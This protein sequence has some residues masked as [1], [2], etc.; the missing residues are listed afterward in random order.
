VP[1][2]Y[3]AALP[4]TLLEIANLNDTAFLAKDG[5]TSEALKQ[6]IP[7][8]LKTLVASARNNQLS[9]PTEIDG[10]LKVN[11]EIVSGG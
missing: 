10:F 3:G 4:Q 8:L 6:V 5:G 2:G 1:F 7:A 11:R 9:V